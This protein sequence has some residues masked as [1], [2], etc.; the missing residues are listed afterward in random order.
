MKQR[1]TRTFSGLCLVVSL[2]WLDGGTFVATERGMVIHSPMVAHASAETT[3]RSEMSRLLRDRK[4][5]SQAVRQMGVPRHQEAVYLDHMEKAWGNDAVM[6]A[7]LDDLFQL[8]EVM[9]MDDPET[10]R[11][12]TR[13]FSSAW[14]QEKSLTGIK[15]LASE[16]QREF[17][18]F[19]LLLMKVVSTKDCAAIVREELSAPESSRVEVQGFSNLPTATLRAYLSIL[20]KSLIAEVTEHPP[21]RTLGPSERMVVEETFGAQL[22][23]ALDNHP[24]GEQLVLGLDNPTYLSDAELCELT[25]LVLDLAVE[26]QGQIGDWVIRYM[27]L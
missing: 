14:F 25:T 15:R 21:I 10:S 24:N 4:F 8:I 5:Q 1:L 19:S 9:H 22:F 23:A 17:F 6:S 2:S 12:L 27:L 18:R 11:N 16:E 20:R 3:F 7:F 13:N 26:E